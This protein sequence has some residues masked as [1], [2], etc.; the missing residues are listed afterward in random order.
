LGAYLELV[1]EDVEF[2]AGGIVM[3]GD[4]HGH[5]EIRG[6][7]ENVLDVLP[8]LTVEERRM[9]RPGRPDARSR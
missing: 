1:D 4:Y 8:D 7:W 9:A 2:A 5:A 3:E 6:F